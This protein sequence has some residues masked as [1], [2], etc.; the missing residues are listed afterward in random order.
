M[1]E[2]K[3]A[4]SRGECGDIGFRVERHT[5]LADA[6]GPLS[7]I[8]RVDRQRVV[9]RVTGDRILEPLI[10]EDAGL[11]RVAWHWRCWSGMSKGQPHHR[12]V[13]DVVAFANAGI[14]TPDIEA[15]LFCLA[16]RQIVE[17]SLRVDGFYCLDLC[18][19]QAPIACIAAVHAAER[20]TVDRRG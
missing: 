16:T 18:V 6:R 14:G 12:L 8:L 15:G 7:R 13:Q 1:G 11:G 20:M 10:R 2:K 5:Q 3:L 4:P 9:V 19:G 17:A